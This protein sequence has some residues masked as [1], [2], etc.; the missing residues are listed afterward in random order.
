[1]IDTPYRRN[2]K[3]IVEEARRNGDSKTIS[4]QEVIDALV[5][6]MEDDSKIIELKPGNENDFFEIFS[7]KVMKRLID[8]AHS[9]VEEKMSKKP[10]A[11][12]TDHHHN[13][14]SL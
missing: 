9:M 7:D 1:M 10:D 11:F 3:K 13:K 4:K 2:A 14:E 12:W 8:I 6:H 5:N